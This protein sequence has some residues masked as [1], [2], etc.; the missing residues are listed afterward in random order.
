MGKCCNKKSFK[1]AKGDK[2]ADG[3][4]GIDGVN[5]IVI[6]YPNDNTPVATTGVVLEDLKS[7]TLPLG[8]LAT[9]GSELIITT[10]WRFTATNDAKLIKVL[11]GGG[12][13]NIIATVTA[14][15]VQEQRVFIVNTI[16]R[17]S[18]TTITNEFD[19]LVCDGI[20][21]QLAHYHNFNTAPITVLDLSANNI[22]VKTQGDGTV[23]G[24]IINDYLEVKIINNA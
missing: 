2:G 17:Q 24:D 16:T 20:T 22:I 18:A 8:T 1:G 21:Q 13:G 3:A 10:A 12:G 14:S 15:T 11:F 6:L 4:D 7:Y 23:I 5:G 9:N 19:I